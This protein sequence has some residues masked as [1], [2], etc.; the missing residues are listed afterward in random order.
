MSFQVAEVG[1][2]EADVWNDFVLRSAMGTYC[3]RY[4]WKA[5]IESSYGLTVKMLA[6]YDSDGWVGIFPVVVMPKLPGLAAR[7]VS[8]AYCNYGDVVVTPRR[9]RDAG[10]A[11]QAC[12]QF[13]AADGVA[14]V[15]VRGL[16]AQVE[17]AA[18]VT[19]MRNLPASADELW[20]QVGDKVRNQIRK[21]KKC[22]LEARWGQDQIKD[23]YAVY[24]ANVGRLGTPVHAEAFF[25]AIV[26]ELGEDSDVLTVRLSGK[27][28]G[29]ML[30][31]KH[32]DIWADPFAASLPEYLHA[33]PNM[34]MYWEVLSAACAQGAKTFD[35]GRSHLGSGTYRFKR[36]WGALP[37]SLLY[38]TY[39][40]GLPGEVASTTRLYRGRSG[41]LASRLWG[42]LPF[43]AQQ[44]VGPWVR[45]WLA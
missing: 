2:Q 16:G 24:A 38:Q 9:G 28:I 12:L 23:L 19:L 39:V 33:N 31:V 3:H 10:V 21:A 22:G 17:E 20:K 45:R 8:V 27:V 41:R 5:I 7:A 42:W 44:M 18:E 30:L 36:Q 29:A 43:R 11:R 4:E 32:G 40:N 15:E 34:F 37:H 35:F 6:A 25:A 13:L 1:V 26:N 14:R